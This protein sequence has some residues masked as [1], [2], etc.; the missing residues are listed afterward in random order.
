M[1]QGIKDGTVRKLLWALAEEGPMTLQ[2]M[3]RLTGKPK[4]CVY[5][6]LT[7]MLRPTIKPAGP[8]RIYI[9]QWVYDQEGQKRY[10]RPMYALGQAADAPRPVADKKA[11][12]KRRRDKRRVML[13]MNSVFNLAALSRVQWHKQCANEANTAQRA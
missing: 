5:A 2:D 7:K 3:V 12:D 9:C 6:L 10:P 1:S 13:T 11:N 8:K 4:E